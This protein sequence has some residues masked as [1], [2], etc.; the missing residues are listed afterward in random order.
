VWILISADTKI[1]T[2]SHL[3][4]VLSQAFSLLDNGFFMFDHC[5]L[6]SGEHSRPKRGGRL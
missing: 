5:G 1:Q 3:D 6:V 4:D 2:N